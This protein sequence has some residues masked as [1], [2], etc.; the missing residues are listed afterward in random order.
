MRGSTLYLLRLVS[1]RLSLTALDAKVSIGNR[2]EQ[3]YPLK[4]TH[5]YL[6]FQT[7]YPKQKEYA[8]CFSLTLWFHTFHGQIIWCKRL[9][10]LFKACIFFFPVSILLWV[11]WLEFTVLEGRIRVIE[12]QLQNNIAS[13]WFS[14]K[15]Y[16]FFYHKITIPLLYTHTETHKIYSKGQCSYLI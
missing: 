10:L 15:F 11:S 16:D 8:G 9:K 7:V 2:K 6:F 14:G 1:T 3:T 12:R 13:Q 5:M 4:M